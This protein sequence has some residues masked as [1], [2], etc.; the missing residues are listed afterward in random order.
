MK[1]LVVSGAHSNVG[2]TT[3]A[4]RLGAMLPGALV[5]KIGHGE[6]KSGEPGR[7]YRVGTPFERILADAP[8]APY[9]VIES[10]SILRELTPDCA[11]F[12]SSDKPKPSAGPALAAAD[13]I[14]GTRTPESTVR[15]LAQG[16][17]LPTKTVR[18]IV[19]LAGSRPEPVTAVILAGGLS[20]R[21]GAD[22]ALLHIGDESVLSR[23][24]H[25]LAQFCDHVVVS[26]SD[27]N[28]TLFGPRHVVTDRVQGQGPLGGI[29]AALA[30]SPTDI[31]LVVACDIPDIDSRTFALLQSEIDGHDIVVP[32]FAPGFVEPLL[33]V[34]RRHVGAVAEQLLAGPRRRVTAL[35]DRCR[36]RIMSLDG[37][38]WYHNL[39]TKA[40]F[41]SYLSSGKGTA[42]V[43]PG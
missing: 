8:D 18:R 37:A 39:N 22:K 29:A 14:S 30:Q 24:E 19:W 41:Q 7:F 25:Q 35:F 38:R 32:S 15:R 9:L 28:G 2:K 20:T 16:L 34:Y 43:R 11:L 10:N 33:G 4:Q 5:V 17:E 23:L 1:T 36:T 26:A 12:L 31:N 40:D 27:R 21:M 42:G 3:L 6:A 13:V